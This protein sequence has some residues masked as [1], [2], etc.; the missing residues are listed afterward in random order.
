M[1]GV[2]SYLMLL[3]LGAALAGAGLAATGVN[4]TAPENPNITFYLW[5]QARAGKVVDPA[6]GQ[7]AGLP[8]KPARERTLLYAA[9]RG[10]TRDAG[11]ESAADDLIR[12]F[13]MVRK[14]VAFPPLF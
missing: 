1:Q 3:M 14:S 6:I 7:A 10:V 4:G 13:E 5:V 11:A 2:S 8:D 12:V 9:L